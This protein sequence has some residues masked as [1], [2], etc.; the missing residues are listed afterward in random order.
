M[1]RMFVNEPIVFRS[2]V[3]FSIEHGGNNDVPIGTGHYT[4]YRN[5]TYF[6]LI[7]DKVMEK[8]DGFSFRE[9]GEGA[10]HSYQAS[11][12]QFFQIQSTL[13]VFRPADEAKEYNLN[14]MTMGAT[15]SFKMAIN[16]KNDGVVLR[17]LLDT[18]AKNQKAEVYVDN[19][20]VGVW[21]NSFAQPYDRGVSAFYSDYILPAAYT[22]GKSSIDIKIVVL[23]DIWTEGGYQTWSI[24][25]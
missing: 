20:L 15:S 21:H 22:R 3:D 11:Q 10:G 24:P 6:Y 13:D 9:N 14:N 1:M 19:T 8:S 16:R 7:P 25:G 12:R 5:L 23:G 17:R 2:E 4:S 18:N